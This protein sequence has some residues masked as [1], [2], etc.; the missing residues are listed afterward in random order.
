MKVV[1][2]YCG[3]D[4]VLTDSSEV[5]RKSY[6]LIWLCRPCGAWVGIHKDSKKRLPLGRLANKE[7]REA[8]IIAHS[9]FDY[10][11]KLKQESQ[12]IPKR[13][14]RGK[15]YKW[16]ASNLEIPMANCHIGMFDVA[17]CLRVVE[18]CKPYVDRIEAKCASQR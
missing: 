16:L 2:D 3:K 15:A 18:I 7:L 6:G 14:A 11:W 17:D 12:G 9:Y 8:K 1:C 4:A 10:L 5:Y 13:K